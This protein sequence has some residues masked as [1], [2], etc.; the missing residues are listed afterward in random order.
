MGLVCLWKCPN[1]IVFNRCG[2]NIIP[3]S[4][5]VLETCDPC[6]EFKR[7]KEAEMKL[8]AKEA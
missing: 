5:A 8:T 6:I 1:I 4:T 2:C 3:N 7:K